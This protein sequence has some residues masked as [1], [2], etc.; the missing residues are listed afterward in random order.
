MSEVKLSICIP[1]YNFG[2]FIGETLRSIVEQASDAVEIVIGDGASTDNTEE[3]VRGYQANFDRLYYYRFEKKGGVD[4]DLDRTVGLAKGDYCWLM[5]SDDV[6]KPGAI[7][8]ML[9]EIE[10]GHDVYLCNRTLCDLHLKPVTEGSWLSDGVQGRS[11]DFADKS[12]LLD[13]L[14]ASKSIGALFS[15]VSSIV[16]HRNR[17][18]EI[19]YEERFTGSNYAHVFRLLSML[20]IRSNKLKYIKESLVLCRGD[21]DSFLDRG[22][23]NRILIDFDGYRRIWE[24]LFSDDD[25]Q[26]AFKAVMRRYRSCWNLAAVKSAVVDDAQWNEIKKGISYYDY[27]YR[28]LLVMIVMGQSKSFIDFLRVMRRFS[29]FRGSAVVFIALI[30]WFMQA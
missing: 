8:H 26:K 6:F 11:Y 19:G 13:Y 5:S 27:S 21:N 24:C 18:N 2:G 7:R 20:K 17:W 28:E 4:Q 14:D 23:A 30:P 25:I 22:V 10:S 15:Y 12:Q 1:T 3:V 29:G 9:A 16:V